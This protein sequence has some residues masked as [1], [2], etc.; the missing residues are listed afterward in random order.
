MLISCVVLECVF[1]LFTSTLFRD[2][3][4]AHSQSLEM[5]AVLEKEQIINMGSQKGKYGQ[6]LIS[7][8]FSSKGTADNFIVR[9][10]SGKDDGGTLIPGVREVHAHSVREAFGLIDDDCRPAIS[11]NYSTKDTETIGSIIRCFST[12]EKEDKNIGT[13]LMRTFST[14]DQH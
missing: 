7:R 12:K 5:G 8:T 13:M 4:S 9:N 3:V 14:K 10:L 1:L 11:R 6:S 2:Y